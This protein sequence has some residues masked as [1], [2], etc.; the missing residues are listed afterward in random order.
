MGRSLALAAMAACIVVTWSA[1]S[2]DTAE[3]FYRGRQVNLI[4]G[5]SPG[6]GYDVYAR[7]LGR[8]I[9]KYIPG[10]PNIVIQ[11]MP[12]AGSLVAANYLYGVAPKD[13]SVFGGFS[14]TAAILA[15]MPSNTKAKFDPRQ[16]TWLGSISSYA[17]DAYVLVVRKDAKA[18]TLEDMR[19]PDGPPVILGS[20]ADGASS[21]AIPTVLR[22]LAGI[23][24]KA[25]SGYKDSSVLFLAVDRA[26]VEGRTVGLSAMRSSKADWLDPKGPMNVVVVMGR[27]TRHPDFP[28]TP[29]LR[30]LAKGPRELAMIEA[31]E[32]PYLMSKPYVAP[33]NVPA[34]RAKALQ[35]AFMA[36]QKD[37]DYLAESEKVGNDISPIGPEE[38]LKVMDK[39]A[40]LP[41]DMLN[42]FDKLLE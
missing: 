28:N 34:E 22:E 17:T 14:R 35:D 42:E 8:H 16:F 9:G 33:P 39:I 37:K 10:N 6:G 21:D 20:T 23:N 13:G 27:A 40:K 38:I 32:V 24:V 41:P 19:K 29:T 5:Y 11:N 36:V 30:E 1:A 2:A 12:G 7:V 15:L 3:S 25:V 31:L 4:I 18:K 26:E